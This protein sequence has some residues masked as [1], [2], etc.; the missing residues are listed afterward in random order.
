MD[1]PRRLDRVAPRRTAALAVGI[2]WLGAAAACFHEDDAVPR[3]DLDSSSAA[4]PLD[5]SDG[6]DTTVTVEPP[7]SDSG[8]QTSADAS[9][10]TAATGGCSLDVECD[11]DNPCTVDLCEAYD[12]RRIRL[13]GLLAMNQVRGDCRVVAC[14]QGEPRETADPTDIPDD[15][16]DCTQDDCHGDVAVHE[17]TPPGVPCADGV[18]CDGS[19][20]CDECASPDT[21]DRLPVDDDCQVRTCIAGACGQ[22]FALAG[23]AVN[24]TLQTP[25]DCQRVVC[26]GA[27]GTTHVAVDDPIVD[28]LE[29]TDDACTDG[30]ADNP[31]WP[32]GTTCAA[33]ECNALGQ[34]VGC[35]DAGDCGTPAQCQTPTCDA[36]GLCGVIDVAAGTPLP[37]GAQT[38]GNCQELRCDGDGAAVAIPDDD[39]LPADAGACTDDVCNGGLPQ[40]PDEPPGTPCNV[41][42]GTRC[43][44]TG[45]CVVCLVAADCPTPALCDV[46]LCEDGTCSTGPAPAA[47]SCSDGLFCTANDACDGAGACVGTGDPCPGAD[48]DADCSE[49]CNELGDDCDAADPDDSGC[50]D[51]LPCTD[52]DRCTSGVCVGGT[53][54]CHGPSDCRDGCLACC[55]D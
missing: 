34:C 44:G 54:D 47:T 25:G 22:S 16:N 15:D 18:V 35:S 49:R 5:G 20:G 7:V 45:A 50:D 41:G 12:C 8:G 42:G 36:Q 51:G 53:V 9:D 26:D 33:G 19:G 38:D 29:C 40:H 30:N 10:S 39:D 4:L 3:D 48:A 24:P 46:A 14:D 28:G 23:T 32:A 1:P 52:G 11:D 43:D 55:D 17:P 37:G 2:A 21:C 27:G 31:P 6:G 13:D